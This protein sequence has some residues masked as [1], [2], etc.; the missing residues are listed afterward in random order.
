MLYKGWDPTSTSPHFDRFEWTISRSIANSNIWI[1]IH[2]ARCL[3]KRPSLYV[4]CQSK[5][6]ISDTSACIFL[7][8]TLLILLIHCVIIIC[9]VLS[10]WLIWN[11]LILYYTYILHE[12]TRHRETWLLGIWS[13]RRTC[14]ACWMSLLQSWWRGFWSLILWWYEKLRSQVL[15]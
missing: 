5:Y 1:W 12:N 4:F 10:K 2:V 15:R 13:L 8:I 9:C 14:A 7:S 11:R 6:L 3:I